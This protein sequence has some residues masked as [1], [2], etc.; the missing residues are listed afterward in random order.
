MF[1]SFDIVNIF[2]ITYGPLKYDDV[3]GYY[4]C[5]TSI[6]LQIVTAENMVSFYV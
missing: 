1:F 2:L 3:V 6:W 5:T 4:L